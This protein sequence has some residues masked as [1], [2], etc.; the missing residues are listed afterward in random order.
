[1]ADRRVVVTGVGMLS[2]VGAGREAARFRAASPAPVARV[3]RR[4]SRRGQ[5][6]EGVK[7]TG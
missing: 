3:R 6:F 2:A 4:N 1:M 5:G 7:V